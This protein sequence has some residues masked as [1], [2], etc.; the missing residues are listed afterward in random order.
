M[1][2]DTIPSMLTI[3]TATLRPAYGVLLLVLTVLVIPGAQSQELD[4]MP[5]APPDTSSPRATLKSFR[6]SMELAFRSFYEHRDSSLLGT[7]AAE[8]RAIDCLDASQ[9][10]PVRSRRLATEAALMLNDVLDRVVMPPDDEIP[11]ALTMAE[12]P[13]D[14]PRAWR[15]PGTEIEI[16]RVAEGR[17]AGEYL[18]SPRTV[19]RAEEFYELARNMPYKPGAMDG[20][21]ERVIYAPGSWIPARWIHA[22]PDWAKQRFGGQSGWKWIAMVLAGAVWLLLLYLGHRMTRPKGGQRRYWLRFFMALA[23]LPVTRGFRAFYEQQLIVVGP[24]YVVVDNIIVMLYY[25]IAAVAILNLGAAVAGSIIASPR[26]D[27]NS[28]DA[29]FVSV[30]CRAVAW[31]FAILVLATGLS[32]LGVPL[33]AVIASLGVGGVAFALAAGPTLENLIAGVTLYL[34][35]PVKIGQFCQFEDVL[36]TVERIGLRSTRIRRWGGNLVAIPNARFAE[37]QLDNFNDARHLW[38]RQRLRLRYETSPEQLAY[39]LA[40]IREML[41]AHPNI[42]SPRARLIGFG[43]D[44]LTV[45]IVCYSDTGVWAQWHAIREDVLLR[46]MEIIEASGTRLALP[47]KTTYVARDVGLDQERRRAAEQQV[48]EWTEAGEL[49]FPDMS[50]EQREALAGTLHFPPEGSVAHKLASEK[51]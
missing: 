39:V 11:D 20:L 9:L 29:D 4:P 50:E 6:D 19:A 28:L 14:V 32:D 15:I 22:L 3:S 45:E 35:K 16:A 10:P 49:P 46:I 36:G 17:R 5:L 43:S 40:K 27:K 7:T 48:R 18:F 1:T 13:P 47:S 12:L 8:S 31:L 33:A 51:D 30:G 44:A 38:I 37:Y 21:Y 42:V 2:A 24:A 41:F 26:I 23:L 25:I 34:D